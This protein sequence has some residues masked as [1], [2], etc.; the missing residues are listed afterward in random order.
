MAY[1]DHSYYT[2]TYM[3]TIVSEADF[4]RLARAASAYIDGIA[5]ST[6][7]PMRPP[8][9]VRDACCAV[10]EVMAAM[11]RGGPLAAVS[12][13]GYTERYVADSPSYARRL[14]AAAYMYMGGMMDAWV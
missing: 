13:D 2:D 10:A 6:I 12:N 5:R 9:S 3:G 1:A 14:F 11:E 8:D 7:N 4:P